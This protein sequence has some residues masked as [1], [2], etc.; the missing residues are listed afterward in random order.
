[1][2]LYCKPS[3]SLPWATTLLQ[4]RGLHAMFTQTAMLMAHKVLVGSPILDRLK[5]RAI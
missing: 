3:Q 4:W 1:M 2:N 5:S